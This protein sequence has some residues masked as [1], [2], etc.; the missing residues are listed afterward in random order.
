[1]LNAA[2]EYILSYPWMAM[3]PGFAIM[4]TALGMNLMGDWLR[5]ILDPRLRRARR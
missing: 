5:D 4:L 2:R 1:M 3:F